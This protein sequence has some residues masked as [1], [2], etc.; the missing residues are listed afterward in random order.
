MF[1]FLLVDDE[2]IEVEEVDGEVERVLVWMRV[3]ICD[4][5]SVLK[6]SKI[7]LTNLNKARFISYIVKS[8]VTSLL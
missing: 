6:I 7:T 5:R 4:N 1:F 8:V 3:A 2:V